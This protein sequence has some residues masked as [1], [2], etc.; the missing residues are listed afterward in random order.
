[1]FQTYNTLVTLERSLIELF[2]KLTD[3]KQIS[4]SPMEQNIFLWFRDMFINSS[5][6]MQPCGM[7]HTGIQELYN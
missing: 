1:M 3:Q 4:L 7:F 5:L 6:K 2:L